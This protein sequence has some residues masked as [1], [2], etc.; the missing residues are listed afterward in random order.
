MK[1]IIVTLNGSQEIELTDEEKNIINQKR[2]VWEDGAFDRAVDNL[3]RRRKPLLQETDYM[4][5]S[6]VNMSDAMRTYRQELRDITNG[7]TT[8]EEVNAVVFPE[9]PLE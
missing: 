4:A 6:D 7:L 1:K 8:V 9:K 2:A 5:N 3:R